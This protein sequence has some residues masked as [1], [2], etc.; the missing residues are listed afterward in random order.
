MLIHGYPPSGTDIGV[1]KQ[2]SS[3]CER[4]QLHKLIKKGIIM[5]LM[6][7]FDCDK[8]VGL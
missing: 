1:V 5:Q 2:D 3:V 4:I 8:W 7:I 6:P